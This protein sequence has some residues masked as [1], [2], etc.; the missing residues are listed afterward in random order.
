MKWRKCDGLLG[1][2]LIEQQLFGG[3]ELGLLRKFLG[4]FGVAFCFVKVLS[5]VG[6]FCF[7][8]IN[9]GFSIETCGVDFG[10]CLFGRQESGLGVAH[11]LLRARGR[12]TA[13]R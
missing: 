10:F 2:L 4:Q 12:K 13:R 3:L 7:E 6:R 5:A 8:I 11:F 1:Y 9:F